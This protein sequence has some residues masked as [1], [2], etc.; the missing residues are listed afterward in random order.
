[1]SLSFCFQTRFCA[2]PCCKNDFY[3]HENEPAGRTHFDMNVF[4]QT[5]FDTAE[6][7]ANLEMGYCCN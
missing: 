5:R 7:K 6:A 1:M 2:N 3:L 4:T